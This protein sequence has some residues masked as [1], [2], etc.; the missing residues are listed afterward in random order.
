MPER[1]RFVTWE[2]G[3]TMPPALALAR[4][5]VARGHE[6]SVLAEPP[7]RAEVEAA[8]CRF[9]SY[10]EAPVRRTRNPADDPFRDWEK[11]PLA[12]IKTAMDVKV[13]GPAAAYARDVLATLERSPADVLVVDAYL[14]GALL[15]AEKSGLPTAAI[16]PDL[17]MRPMPG[18]PPGGPGFAPA[19]GP[20]GRLRDRIVG[21]MQRR[22]FAHG[23]P[24]LQAACAEL[25]LAP[26]RHVFEPL[27]RIDRHLLL[28]A[29]AYDYPT[30]PPANLRY[31]GPQLDDPVWAGAWE[32]PRPA[33]DRPLVL[34][35]L[36]ST[37]QDQA[38]LYRKVIEA[39]APLPVRGLVTL[40]GVLDP[41]DFA[42]PDH[43]HVVTSAPHQAVLEH[44]AVAVTHCGHGSV[45]RALAAG[46]PLVCLPIGRDQNENAARVAAHGA[47]LR[48]RSGASPATIRRAIEKVLADPAHRQA[49]ATLAGA[50]E[51]ELA[52]DPA[53]AELEA[54]ARASAPRAASRAKAG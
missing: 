4:R 37:F 35:S 5:L 43:I 29:R 16:S 41:A 53:V 21:A 6:V 8:G 32:P 25:G 2:G 14:L 44:A 38:A 54:L 7:S 30:E 3:G 19:T 31:V 51:R 13:C 27:E 20:L 36:G 9:E 50:I 23:L 40:G 10:R 15:A 22:L 18:R 12:A 26:V 48:L 33:D 42:A 46:V 24:G 52:G 28:T 11:N 17:G 39:L 47:G 1:F 49:A 34:V 45:M